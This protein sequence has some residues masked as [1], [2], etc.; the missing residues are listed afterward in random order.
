MSLACQRLP[1]SRGSSPQCQP[2]RHI[3]NDVD[4]DVDDDDDD[5]GGGGGGVFVRWSSAG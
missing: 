3:I 4:D 5:D 2:E 1:A